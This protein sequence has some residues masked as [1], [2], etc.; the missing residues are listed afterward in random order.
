MPPLG[1][2]NSVNNAGINTQPVT[3]R[4]AAW[5]SMDRTGE[6]GISSDCRVCERPKKE[7][8]LATSLH[9]S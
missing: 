7:G 5:E 9:R 1:R 6:T 2:S 3:V 8:A 4:I